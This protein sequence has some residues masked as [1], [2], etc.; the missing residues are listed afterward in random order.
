MQAIERTD[1]REERR[2]TFIRFTERG[3]EERAY[4]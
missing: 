3:K 1:K 4:F 2:K